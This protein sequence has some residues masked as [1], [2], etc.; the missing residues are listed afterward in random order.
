MTKEERT[1]KEGLLKNKSV[2]TKKLKMRFMSIYIFS[3]ID[4]WTVFISRCD[5]FIVSL[6]ICLQH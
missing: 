3:K 5:E 6:G 2:A 1:K 4:K